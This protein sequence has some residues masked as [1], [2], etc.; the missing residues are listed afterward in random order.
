MSFGYILMAL[1]TN[2]FVISTQCAAGPY[3][4]NIDEGLPSSW[5]TKNAPYVLNFTNISPSKIVEALKNK[6]VVMIGD[7]LTRYQ[8][9]NIVHYLHV[10]SWSTSKPSYEYDREWPSWLDFM[11]GTNAGLSCMEICDCYRIENNNQIIRENRHFFDEGNNI[12]IRYFSW[13]PP[14]IRQLITNI[15]SNTDI[16]NRCLNYK[17]SDILVN[18]FNPDNPHKSFNHIFDFLNEVLVPWQPDIVLINCGFWPCHELKHGHELK[19][20]IQILLSSGK[21]IIWKSTTPRWGGPLVRH[22][23]IEMH[24]ILEKNGIHVFNTYDVLKSIVLYNSSYM[25][26]V[27]FAPFVHR[28]LNKGLIDLILSINQ[29]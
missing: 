11:K 17:I 26:D 10:G 27:H 3:I 21:N 2:I 12:S 5:N 18:D 15:P 8:Y 13:F 7:S 29:E 9:L 4:W 24:P 19:K 23:E 14:G 1:F 16:S 22:E 6:V 20:F 28:E 25:D